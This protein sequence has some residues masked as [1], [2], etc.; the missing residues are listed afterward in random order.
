MLNIQ[1]YQIIYEAGTL[2]PYV[3]VATRALMPEFQRFVNGMTCVAG[4]RRVDSSR[5]AVGSRG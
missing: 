5:V 2:W 4:A 3:L 1:V